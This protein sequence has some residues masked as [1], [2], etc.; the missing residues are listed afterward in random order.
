MTSPNADCLRIQQIYDW[1]ITNKNG[2]VEP[3]SH[4]ILSL[5]SD[6]QFTLNLYSDFQTESK[7][8]DEHT[9]AFEWFKKAAEQCCAEAQYWLARCYDAGLGCSQN[10]ELAFTWL[11][12]AAE[13]G[14]A[15]AYYYLATCYR[16]GKGVA[17]NEQLAFDWITKAAELADVY[18][19]P[20]KPLVLWS[21]CCRSLFLFR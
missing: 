5:Y 8:K 12:K 19:G 14:F 18:L 13:Q 6:F 21:S 20:L 7:P 17:Q 10:D 2:Y 15:E 16:D 4:D 1:V 3:K 11:K 9:L